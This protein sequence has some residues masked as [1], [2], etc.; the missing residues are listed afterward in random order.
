MLLKLARVSLFLIATM[1]A[2]T[3]QG[4][5]RRYLDQALGIQRSQYNGLVDARI[6]GGGNVDLWNMSPRCDIWVY[7]K[8]TMNGYTHEASIYV[9][10]GGNRVVFAPG[11]RLDR[12][13]ERK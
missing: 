8:T 1:A 3:S 12:V 7:Y 2:V 11:F 9:K 5:D 10:F 13:E 4:A 6:L